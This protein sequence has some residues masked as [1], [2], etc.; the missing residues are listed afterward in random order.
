M[1]KIYCDICGEHA[2][3]PDFMCDVSVAEIQTALVGNV[4][5]QQK[6]V[7]KD[8]YQFCRDCFDKKISKLIKQ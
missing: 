5:T 7:K 2:N 1:I 4:L 8:T 6:Q 3:D